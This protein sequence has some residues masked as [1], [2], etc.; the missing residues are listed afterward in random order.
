[1]EGGREGGSALS[2]SLYTTAADEQTDMRVLCDGF[3]NEKYDEG[4]G[5]ISRLALVDLSS[6]V[7]VGR[8]PGSW[9]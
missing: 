5:I 9:I 3:A 4:K 6:G 2:E 7:R 1:M 8:H